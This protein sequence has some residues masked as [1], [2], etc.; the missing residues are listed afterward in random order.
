METSILSSTKKI[1]G[2]EPD[3]ESFDLDVL[4]HINSAFSILSDIGIGPPGGY[5]ISDATDTWDDLEIESQEI[6]NLIKTCIYLR[7]RLLFD[8][9]QTSYLQAAFQHQ[10]EEHEW[11][12]NE[13]RE[14]TDWVDPNP[15]PV[16]EAI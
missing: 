6:V 16:G 8:P 12:L 11:R 5:A 3:D 13:M 1:L 4:T 2:L 15:P 14:N 9:P 10:I 7:V